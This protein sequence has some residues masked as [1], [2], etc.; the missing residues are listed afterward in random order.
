LP[1]YRQERYQRSVLM[2][3]PEDPRKG[4][5]ATGEAMPQVGKA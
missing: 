4:L 5:V 2:W 3:A 1:W